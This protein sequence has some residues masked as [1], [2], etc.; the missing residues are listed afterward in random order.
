MPQREPSCNNDMLFSY[1][2][3][4]ESIQTGLFWI[5]NIVFRI[6]KL[7]NAYSHLMSCK[8]F[9][10]CDITVRNRVAIKLSDILSLKQRFSLDRLISYGN[11]LQINVRLWCYYYST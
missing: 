9:S 5:R 4:H 10:K 11:K 3:D 7:I 8:L 6:L 1:I 2:S